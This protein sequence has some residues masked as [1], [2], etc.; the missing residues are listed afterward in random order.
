MSLL[1]LIT[2]IEPIHRRM[3]LC[4]PTDIWVSK[5]SRCD[6]ANW[7]PLRTVTDD[8]SVNRTWH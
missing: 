1:V 8:F 5:T 2:E 3:V 6:L 4:R 7:H